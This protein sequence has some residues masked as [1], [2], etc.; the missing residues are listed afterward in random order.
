MFFLLF[1][2]LL[3]ILKKIDFLLIVNLELQELSKQFQETN[4]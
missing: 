2:S 4:I 1:R 3:K